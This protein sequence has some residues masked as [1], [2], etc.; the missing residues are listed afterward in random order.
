MECPNCTFQNSP[1]LPVCVRCQSRLDL[2][3]VEI[4]PPRAS[5]V[6]LVR[7]SSRVAFRVRV[8]FGECVRSVV[9]SASRLTGF[10][11]P[12]QLPLSVLLWSIIPGMGQSRCGQRLLG[13]TLMVCWAICVL[14]AGL[15]VGSGL[16]YF[17]GFGAIGVH[18]FGIG[19]LLAPTMTR[20]SVLA[21][22]VVGIGTWCVLVGVIYRPALLF[23]EL[24]GVVT[25]IADIR[26]SAIVKDGDVLISTG[27]WTRPREFHRGEIVSYRIDGFS[28]PAVVV[29]QG[30]GIDRIV[31]LPG[32][33]VEVRQ[34]V[35]SV[36]GRALPATAV[37]G[38]RLISPNFSVKAGPDEYIV[39]PSLL[40]W[41]EHGN[42]PNVGGMMAGVSRV[43]GSRIVGRV[44]GRIRPWSRM[45]LL[46]GS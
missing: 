1:G 2:S 19:L 22:L 15:F 40:R 46:E 36:N 10:I 26:P 35:I 38:E 11:V 37:L 45:S 33:L 28:L 25:P 31:G 12:V 30:A 34:G 32:D 29:K 3:G 24:L 9:G 23:T 4:A 16:G 21:R 20:S 41:F 14:L 27:A 44:V 6:A 39:V 42:V 7:S 43:P 18:C 17:F 13:R 5:G 8:G